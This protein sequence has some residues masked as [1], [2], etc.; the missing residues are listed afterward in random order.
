[1]SARYFTR[2]CPACPF[3]DKTRCTMTAE[4]STFQD[5]FA[6]GEF[7]SIADSVKLIDIESDGP[8]MLEDAYYVDCDGMPVGRVEGYWFD[9]AQTFA[10]NLDIVGIIRPRVE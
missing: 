8:T 7:I 4:C 5:L 3:W 2:D 10:R 6:G 9:M 1:M